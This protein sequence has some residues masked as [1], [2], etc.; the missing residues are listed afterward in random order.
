M[1]VEESQD[2]HNTSVSNNTH[3]YP[4]NQFCRSPH[5]RRSSLSFCCVSNITNSTVLIDHPPRSGEQYSE[6]E[7]VNSARFEPWQRESI[8]GES[9]GLCFSVGWAGYNHII[10][11]TYSCKAVNITSVE[12]QL[13]N[14]G[15]Y[16]IHGQI[17][18]YIILIQ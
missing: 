4:H 18:S 6:L 11:G 9:S 3:L 2:M 1:F 10:G 8:D 14:I 15:I 5:C 13:L 7:N 12:P 16:S 17:K